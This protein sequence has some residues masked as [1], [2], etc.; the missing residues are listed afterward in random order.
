MKI[1]T[2]TQIG[3]ILCIVVTVTLGLF[4]FITIQKM[5]HKNHEIILVAKIVKDMA[6]LKIV[7]HEYLLYSEERSLIQWKSK[8]NL[9]SQSFIQEKNKAESQ[10]EKI[11]FS[12]IHQNLLEIG[13]IFGELSVE[14]KK[15]PINNRQKYFF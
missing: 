8:Y 10:N 13:I 5:N 6:E 9:L 2:I 14:L 1:K 11:L 15:E 7:M 3:T 4:V 12:K